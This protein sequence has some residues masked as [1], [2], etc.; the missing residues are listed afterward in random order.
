MSNN[1]FHDTALVT[2]GASG[3]GFELCKL[4]AKDGHDLVLVDM[5]EVGML[6]A[7]DQLRTEY[8]VKVKV[9]YKDL[10]DPN[11]AKEI[12]EK[13]ERL[14]IEITTLVNNAGYGLSGRF[15]ELELDDQLQMMQVN[16]NAVVSLTSYFLPRLLEQKQA[17]ILNLASIAAFQAGPFMATYFA[18]KAFVLSFSEALASELTG[19]NVSVTSVCPGPTDT[20]FARRA[21]AN[22]SIAFKKSTM[23]NVVDVA[24][25][26]YAAMKSKR[27]VVIPGLT[28]K[29][30][31]LASRFVP[32]NTVTQVAGLMNKRSSQ[33]ARVSNAAV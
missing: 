23:M 7:A 16:M 5:N 6:R 33:I 31:I 27:A 21:G 32:R 8:G 12:Y 29:M 15:T 26:A 24:H 10:S 22:G 30:A 17:S 28:N 20:G 4:L 19:T 1:T 13:L 2:G 25:E 3:I 11:A 18:S 9:L 14:G